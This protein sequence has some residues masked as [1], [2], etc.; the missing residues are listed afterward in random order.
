MGKEDPDV[1]REISL[2]R[3]AARGVENQ[4]SGLGNVRVGAEEILSAAA[5][6]GVSKPLLEAI[7]L[8]IV[9]DLAQDTSGRETD[10][11]R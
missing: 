3:A 10:P 2:A 6:A 7:R 9:T 1:L 4:S 5:H 11:P 8:L